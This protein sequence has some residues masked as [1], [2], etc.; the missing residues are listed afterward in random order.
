MLDSQVRPIAQ[1]PDAQRF[2]GRLNPERAKP[3]LVKMKKELIVFRRPERNEDRREKTGNGAS[4]QRDRE[5][6]LNHVDTEPAHRIIL[7]KLSES[8]MVQGV[9]F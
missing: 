6:G 9:S 5:N 7:D 4:R 3:S 8:V 1:H 2:P